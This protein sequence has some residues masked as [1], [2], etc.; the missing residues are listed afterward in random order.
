LKDSGFIVNG[1]G[2]FLEHVP[3]GDEAD[4]VDAVL[5]NPPFYGTH[6][7]NHV[8]HAMKW[9]K[10]GGELVAV[11]PI[12]VELG[13][14]KEHLAFRE[15][16]G[17]KGDPPY[18]RQCRDLPDGSFSESGTNVSTLIFTIAKGK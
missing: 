18:H 5:M 6:W 8:M 10:P 13:Q 12:S 11:L 16:A 3:P 7:M 15:W 9:L 14:T 1:P 17:M 4:K 2:D